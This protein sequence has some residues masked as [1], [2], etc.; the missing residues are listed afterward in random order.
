[1]PQ[2]ETVLNKPL[3]GSEVR[4]IILNQLERTLAGD[5]RLADYLAFPSF[6]FRLEL[7]LVLTGAPEPHDQL[8]RVVEGG[9]GDISSD[10]SQIA[11]AL[12]HHLEQS[13]LPPNQ[14]RMENGLGIPVLTHDEKGRQIEKEIRYGQPVQRRG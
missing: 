2:P 12:T 10:P 8:E 11:T 14:A 6:S 4:R 9:V 1:M 5:S 3:S 7:A 13:P